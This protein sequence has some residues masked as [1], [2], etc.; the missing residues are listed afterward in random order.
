MFLKCAAPAFAHEASITHALARRTPHAVPRVVA[1]EPAENWLLMHDHGGRLLDEG[2][3]A[4]WVQAMPR[5]VELQRSWIGATGAVAAAGG[6]TRPL[7]RLATT[8]PSMLDRDGLGGRLAPEVRD[9]WERAIP[10]LQDACAALDD[11]GLPDA[12]VHGDLHPG[13]IV[14]T[15]EGHRVVDWS[16]AAVGHPFVDLPTFLLRTKDVELRRRLRDAYIGGWDGFLPHA[17]LEPAADLATAVGAL[18]QVA[19]YQ[20]LLPAMDEP[21]RALFDGA[22]ASWV[23]RTLEGLEHGIEAQMA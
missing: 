12:L 16:D 9:A 10:R 15:S 22:D 4:D 1:S 23:K 6:Q 7:E 3:E 19:T 13:N 11:L 8:L 5:G 2:P 18:Y 20:A 17:R 21:D 14:L